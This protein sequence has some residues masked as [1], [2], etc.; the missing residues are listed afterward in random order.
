MSWWT[1]TAEN[2]G[3]GA[4]AAGAP[5]PGGGSPPAPNAAPG[6]GEG[7]S[8]GHTDL[9]GKPE[10]MPDSFWVAP[11]EGGTA[12]YAK[13]AEKMAGA[14]KEG[15]Q[16]IQQQGE[17]LAKYVV[18][19]GTAPYFEGLDKATLL[20]THQRSGLDEAQM[21][22]F[23]AQARSAG[24][25]PAPA[26]AL[27]QSWM[28][29]RHE[30]TP[31]PKEAAQLHEE[32]VAALNGQGR[33]GSEMARRVRSWVGTMVD[34]SKLSAEQAESLGT[35]MQSSHGIEAL[36]ALI[37]N[38]PASP[39]AGKGVTMNGNA[40]L[41]ALDKKVEDPRFGT[42]PMYTE[43]VKREMEQH[44]SLIR[45]RYDPGAIPSLASGPMP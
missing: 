9:T 34:S 29:S 40:I 1:E 10:W 4:G 39:A 43:Q 31:V 21:D 6:A 5:T 36:H 38:V 27:L 12:D 22:Q 11:G 33:P 20:A 2:A 26:Q 45:T 35:A 37:G 16:K 13:M 23:M 15:R 25:G 19:E 18:P 7:P 24:V 17:S 41:D 8:G 42:D 14:L 44:E 28:R 3:T 32:A 30:A